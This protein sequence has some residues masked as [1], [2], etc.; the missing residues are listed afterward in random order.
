MYPPLNR[1]ILLPHTIVHT[2]QT[3]EVDAAFQALLDVCAYKC[4]EV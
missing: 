2:L 4:K 3:N 1:H